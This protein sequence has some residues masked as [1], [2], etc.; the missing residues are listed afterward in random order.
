M[1][2]AVDSEADLNAG[3]LGAD[4]DVAGPFPDRLGKDGV[5]QTDN[6]RFVRHILERGDLDLLGG[7]IGD[8]F[9]LGLRID[10]HALQDA[11]H[12]RLHPVDAVDQLV[13]FA[14]G[15]DDR[16][17]LGV[18]RDFDGIQGVDIEGIRHGDGQEPPLLPERRHLE[19]LGGLDRDQAGEVDVDGIAVGMVFLNLEL[20]AQH[21][22]NLV[23]IEDSLTGEILSQFQAGLP[24]FGKGLP[25]LFFRQELALDEHFPQS[26]FDD[27]KSQP[28][29]IST[30]RQAQ[31][32]RFDFLQSR[33]SWINLRKKRY[34]SPVSA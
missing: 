7:L 23:F 8:L 20:F 24:V 11:A 34:L 25:E 1:E 27:H 15:A 5:D 17:H 2:L 18:G 10:L 12:S 26:L 30:L 3:L 29:V 19:F 22:H 6:R 21:I 32:D 9:H 28:Y 33:H 31:G 4:V 16:F 13:Q 14:F